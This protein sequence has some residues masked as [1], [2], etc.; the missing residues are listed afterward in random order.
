MLALGLV[1]Y[2]PHFKAARRDPAQRLRSRACTDQAV[3]EQQVQT[4]R[5]KVPPEVVMANECQ[6]AAAMSDTAMS[7][8]PTTWPGLVAY[9]V[10]PLPS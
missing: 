8:K 5:L 9:T 6:P 1:W 4:T 2:L 7:S 10:E 3:T